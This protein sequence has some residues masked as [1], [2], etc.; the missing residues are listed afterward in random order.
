MQKITKLVSDA[1]IVK[2]KEKL[3]NQ[4]AQLLSLIGVPQ[5]ALRI[6]NGLI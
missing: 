6:I 4:K 1:V 3:N 5:Q 2:Q